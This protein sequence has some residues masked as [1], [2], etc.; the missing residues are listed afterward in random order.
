M[1]LT[2]IMQCAPGKEIDLPTLTWVS[3]FKQEQLD[4]MDADDILSDIMNVSPT[5]YF[6]TEKKKANSELSESLDNKVGR[7]LNQLTE[8]S[9]VKTF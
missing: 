3:S 2:G 5:C 6:K 1:A 4:F 8:R 9:F 7:Y